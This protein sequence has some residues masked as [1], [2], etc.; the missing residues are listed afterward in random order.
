M[1]PWWQSFFVGSL[2]PLFALSLASGENVWSQTPKEQIRKVL[3][4]QVEA[5]NRGDIEGYMRGYWNSDS[6]QFVSGGSILR[7]WENV[8]ERY[9]KNYDTRGK[10][11]KLE[12]GELTIRLLS[13]TTAVAHGIWKLNRA[14]DRP[15]GRFT[16]VVEKK[17]EG[18]RITHDHTSS[19][20]RQ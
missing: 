3:E 9:K 6:T 5:W 17:K 11:G 10:M 7:G 14:N 2:V 4:D 12:F 13:P 1:V 8:L 16:L 20:E 19:A 15:W 18:W